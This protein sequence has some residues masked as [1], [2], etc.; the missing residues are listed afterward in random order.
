MKHFGKQL[1]GLLRHPIVW[2]GAGVIVVI[3]L[4]WED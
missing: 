4:L 2:I 1:I 3:W